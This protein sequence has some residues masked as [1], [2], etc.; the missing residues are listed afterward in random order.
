MSE[1]M[2]IIDESESKKII[3]SK[4]RKKQRS[5]ARYSESVR[6]KCFSC[7]IK[8]GFV[9]LTCKASLT[10]KSNLNWASSI[11]LKVRE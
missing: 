5:G 8:L 1:R 2:K 3:K 7:T 9:K 11:I 10:F 4:D 6:T